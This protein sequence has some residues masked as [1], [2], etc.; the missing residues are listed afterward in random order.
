MR[1]C[2]AVGACRA[3]P[4]TD[5]YHRS[6]RTG[7]TLD[8]RPCIHWVESKDSWVEQQSRRGARIVGVELGE[9]STALKAV[10]VARQRT[11]VLLGNETEGIP[12]NV[13]SFIDDVVSIPMMGVGRSLNVAVAG[14]L[15]LYKLSGLAYE[16]TRP[17][18]AVRS[19]T[20]SSR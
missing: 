15:V 14:S 5:H 3:V 2:D 17:A 18:T 20:R 10:G 1:T 16:L 9:D 11:V 19:M 12:R 6:L 7:D 8:V 4:D 13:W